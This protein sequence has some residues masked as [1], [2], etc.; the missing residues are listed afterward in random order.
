[1]P[2]GTFEMRVLD[3]VYITWSLQF[4]NVVS[5]HTKQP[6]ENKIYVKG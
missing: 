2:P 6:K 4:Q 1:M 5:K 3:G